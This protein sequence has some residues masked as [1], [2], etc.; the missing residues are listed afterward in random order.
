MTFKCIPFDELTLNELY[1]IMQLR[2]EVFIVEQNCPFID[3]DGKDQK[4][5]HC[6]GFDDENNLVAYTRL[7]DLSYYYEGFTSIGRVV[8]SAK[9][10]RGGA[11]R[12]LMQQSID[13]CNELFGNY[14]IKIGAQKYLEKF[15]ESFGFKST[16]EDYIEDGIP[17]TIMIRNS[18][19]NVD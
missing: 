12:V 13:Y 10:R 9:V 11:G 6:M 8:T 15:Y 14:P 7:F 3:A 5:W 16:G 17:H 19:S 4:A 1:A 18:N 2:Q